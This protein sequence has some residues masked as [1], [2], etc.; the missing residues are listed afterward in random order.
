MRSVIS[1]VLGGGVD[2]LLGDG[3]LPAVVGKAHTTQDCLVRKHG[4]RR[5]PRQD[6]RGGFVSPPF[7]FT[8]CQENRGLA[9][10][11]LSCQELR[12]APAGGPKPA[13]RHLQ[14]NLH[15]RVAIIPVRPPDP[16]SPDESSGERER[17]PQ[18]GS[19]SPFSHRVAYRLLPTAYS[20]R[21]NWVRFPHFCIGLPIARRLLPTLTAEIGF[22]F[23]I[24]VSTAGAP[25]RGPRSLGV[26]V[27]RT[28]I[29][30]TLAISMYE[31]RASLILYDAIQFAFFQLG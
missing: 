1:G 25:P 20:D 23:P 12:Q 4:S 10:V 2:D 3:E 19:F 17:Q 21:R 5:D 13:V 15:N 30:C 11:G 26:A 9:G 7:L 28:P 29:E 16:A 14:F 31:G 18:L 22:V 6:F 8:P 27:T 24:F